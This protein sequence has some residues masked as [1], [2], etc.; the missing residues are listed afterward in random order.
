MKII[1]EIP[2]KTADFAVAALRQVAADHEEERINAAYELCK[3]SPVTITK[4]DLG[5]EGVELISSLTMIA[6]GLKIN[7]LP[8][9]K[10][11]LQER[12]EQMQKERQ[13]IIDKA[14]K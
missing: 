14:N 10:S 3:A 9:Q 11:A 8:K 2:E 7:E 12:L 6:I 4:D 5:E 1:L 13:E